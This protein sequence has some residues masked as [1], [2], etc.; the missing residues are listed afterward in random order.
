VFRIEIELVPS[1]MLGRFGPRWTVEGGSDVPCRLG[2]AAF[3][4][5]HRGV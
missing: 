5:Q 3:L 1:P 2:R 4:A